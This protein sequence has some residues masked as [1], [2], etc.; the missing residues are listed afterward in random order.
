[1]YANGMT[2][3]KAK[4]NRNNTIGELLP[5]D[6]AKTT[7]TGEEGARTF[8]PEHKSAFNPEWSRKIIKYLIYQEDCHCSRTVTTCCSGSRHPRDAKT[9]HQPAKGKALSMARGEYAFPYPGRQNSM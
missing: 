6:K 3:P 9:D 2:S 8:N 7:K 5:Q 4:V 1:V